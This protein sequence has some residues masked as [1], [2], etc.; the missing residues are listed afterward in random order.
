MD[1]HGHCDE[2]FRPLSDQLRVNFERHGE[3]GA[4]VAVTIEGRPVVDIWAG[5]M[6]VARTRRWERDTLVDVFSAGKPMVA[7]CLLRLVEQGRVELDAPVASYWP[8]FAAAGKDRVTV[9][10]LLGHRA[11]LPAI[12][13]E[14]PADAMYDWELMTSALAAEEPW[15]EPGAAHGYHT[16]T[17]GFLVGELVRRVSGE[18]VGEVFRRA[19]AEPLGADFHFGLPAADDARV[20]EFRFPDRPPESMFDPDTVPLII[21]RAYFNPPGI[22]GIGTVNT[23]EWRAAVMPST[24]GHATARAVARIY[25][26]LDRILKP[27]TLAEAT[28][29]ASSGPDRVLT[30]PSR[31]G[32][33]FQLTM[34]ERPLGPNPGAFGHFGAGGSLGFADPD[35]GL[36]FAYTPNQGEGP[37]W[38]NPR[39]RG[40][41]EALYGC[42]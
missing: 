15:W 17:Y 10:E 41:I 2:R 26:A 20:A 24:N 6:D 19:I 31:F 13:R 4:A 3:V 25:A 21:R 23:R 8:A 38:Q 14:L 40:L 36:A 1:I 9:R 28:R 12:R 37:R 29:E 22:S 11:G 32:L 34:P 35:V 30:R 16:N 33:G 7:L 5:W 42:L 27:E 39:N 18:G